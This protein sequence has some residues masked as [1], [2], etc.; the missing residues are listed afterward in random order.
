MAGQQKMQNVD[1]QSTE[2]F[3]AFLSQ[4]QL[5]MTLLLKAFLLECIPHVKENLSFNVPYFKVHKNI[6]FI[7][8]ADVLWGKKKK[9]VGVRIGFTQGFRLTDPNNFLEK[10]SR[11]QVY[12]KTFQNIGQIEKDADL[13]KALIYEAALLDRAVK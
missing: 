13:L 7:W 12:Y 3:Y 6:A 1:F 2:E 4:E 11:K 5:H 8:P 9:H 10:G